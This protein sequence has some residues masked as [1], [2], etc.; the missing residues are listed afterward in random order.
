MPIRK[1]PRIL[2]LCILVEAL[3]TS[4]LSAPEKM[5]YGSRAGMSVTI[6][7]VS[8]VNSN[9]ASLRAKHTRA[10]A[11][12]FCR[13]YVGKVTE[14]CIK[15]TLAEPLNDHVVA[16][17]ESGEFIDFFGDRYQFLGPNLNPADQ[18]A[19]KYRILNLKDNEQADGSSASA[20]TERL[21]I[22]HRLCP[23]RVPHPDWAQ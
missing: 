4:A 15:E 18:F 16:N 23:R 12:A 7:S 10:D 20:Y 11:I 3:Q 14:K 8:G 17:C 22:F 13:E 5:P 2:T 19:P 6:I 1:I 9:H 21:I